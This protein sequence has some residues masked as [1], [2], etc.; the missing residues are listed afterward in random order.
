MRRYRWIAALLAVVPLAINPLAAHADGGIPNSMASTGDSITRAFDI[1]W[2]CV[3]SDSPQY[4]WSTGDDPAVYSLYLRLLEINPPIRGN[5]FNFA[6]SG[7]KMVDL[8]G[9][10]TAAAGRQVQ[11]ATVLMGANDVCTSTRDGMTRTDVFEAQFNQAMTRF[12]QADPNA[13]IFVL[14][15]PNVYQLWS[16]LH[17]NWLAELFWG[18]FGICQSMLSTSNTEADR[19]AVLAQERADNDALAR[20]CARFPRCV[21]DWETTF[22]FQFSA[23]DVSSVDYFHP[24]ITGQNRLAEVAWNFLISV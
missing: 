16:V 2:C 22:N 19:Q 18:L 9:Q 11:F 17:D 10:L 14:S 13:T 7:G 8:D 21:W 20:V 1:D 12:T 15:I 24:S 5:N 4:S 23:A 3:L 6:R